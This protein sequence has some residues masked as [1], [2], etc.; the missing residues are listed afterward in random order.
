MFLLKK[1]YIKTLIKKKK[2]KYGRNNTGRIT[3]RSW[4][5]GHKQLYRKINFKQNLNKKGLIVN[6]EYDPNRT[7]FIYKILYKKNKKF[8]FSYYLCNQNINVLQIIKP[9]SKN[10]IPTKTYNKGF[11]FLIKNLSIGDI[12]SNLEKKP[13]EGAVFIRSA[14]TFG[15]IIE[16]INTKTGLS[17]IQLP[18][19]EQYFVSNNCKT[20][21][22]RSSNVFHKHL[23]KWK[24]GTSRHL[25]KRPLTRGVAKNPVDHPHGGGEGKAS[26]GRPPVTPQGFLTK[27]VK[28][29]KKRKNSFFI[30]LRK[31]KINK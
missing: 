22:G 3:V 2:Q 12:I 4:Q 31:N 18:S 7:N 15:K 25:G 14:G 29:R 19:K 8:Y 30:A 23:N 11:S 9:I 6:I 26:V 1:Q 27:G 24:A 10:L 13:T 20:N 28:T 21:L 17:R 5:K 16:I